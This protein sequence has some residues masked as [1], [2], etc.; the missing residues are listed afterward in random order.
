MLA[1]RGAV[2]CLEFSRENWSRRR[3]AW[4]MGRDRRDRFMIL[5]LIA[6]QGRQTTI[7]F[8]ANVSSNES[9]AAARLMLAQSCVLAARSCASSISPPT[10]VVNGVDD[11]ISLWGSDRV[12]DLIQTGAYDPLARSK[13]EAPVLTEIGNAERFAAAYQRRCSLLPFATFVVRLG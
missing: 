4:W 13:A 6:W 1:D 9:V 7:F 11:L 3:C 2:R 10:S 8:D 12:L 5:E